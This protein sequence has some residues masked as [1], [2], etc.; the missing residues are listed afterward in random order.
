MNVKKD[1]INQDY[2]C[3]VYY[4]YERIIK[5]TQGKFSIPNINYGKY[6]TSHNTNVEDFVVNQ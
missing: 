1:Q 2:G 6:D 3:K 4:K 5:F